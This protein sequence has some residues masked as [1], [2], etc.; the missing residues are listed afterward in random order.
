V[1][2]GHS[3]QLEIRGQEWNAQQRRGISQ[4]RIP[5]RKN[6]PYKGY[7]WLK[8]GEFKGSVSVSLSQD[9]VDGIEYATAVLTDIK[10]GWSKYEFTLTP[11]HTDSLAKLSILFHGLGRIWI[12]QVSLMPGDSRDGVREDVYKRVSDLHPSFVRW[13]GG[14]VAQA[15]HWRWGIGPRDDR[16][17][18]INKAWW[19]ET[20]TGDLGTD[21]F[22]K[23][24]EGLHAKPSITVNVEGDGATAEEAANWVE[25]VNGPARSSFGRMRAANGHP[26][27]YRVKLWEVGNE[28]FG[29]WEIGHTD[30]ETYARNLIRYAAAM[31]AVDPTIQLIAVGSEDMEW[32]R[33]VLEIAGQWIDYLAVHHYYGQDQMNGDVK[34]LLA[35]PLEYGLFYEQMKELMR[36]VIPNRNIKLSINEWNTSLPVPTQHTM[37]SALYAARLMNTFERNGDIVGTTSVSDMVNGWSGGIIQA[38]RDQ[39]YV[40]PT[41]LVNKLYNDHLERDRLAAKIESPTFETSSEGAKVPVLDAVVGRSADGSKIF[42]KLVNVD[43]ARDMKIDISV[44]GTKISSVGDLQTITSASPE[45]ETSFRTPTAIAILDSIVPAANEFAIVLP[46]DSVAVLTLT[47][48][49]PADAR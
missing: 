4:S 40:T 8:G 32:N 28:V 44:K 19:N 42:F 37:L 46:R 24:C 38:S 45:A 10:A 17:E 41:Y 30:A 31:K 20:E 47:V 23:I 27:P 9:Q 15:Y 35:H 2:P 11:D 39:I 14:N 34:N 29:K 13:P 18:W 21:E 22:I 26:E 1:A 12:D 43:L 6:I 33:T 5:V 49:T 16:P 7:V 3:L 36:Q 25:Y 48:G